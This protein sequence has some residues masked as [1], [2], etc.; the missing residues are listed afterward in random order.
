MVKAVSGDQCRTS[1]VNKRV[2]RGYLRLAERI[3]G[4]ARWKQ[5]KLTVAPPCLAV[6]SVVGMS[7]GLRN[8]VTL[9]QEVKGHY[10]GI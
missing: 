6:H 10:F 3:P 9:L 8:E 4:L 5:P 2:V 7:R 1:L